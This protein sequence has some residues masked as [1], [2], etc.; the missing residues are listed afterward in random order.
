MYRPS[1]FHYPYDKQ[2]DQ[3]GFQVDFAIGIRVGY[4]CHPFIRLDLGWGIALATFGCWYRPCHF[5]CFQVGLTRGDW[6]WI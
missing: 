1:L 3:A 6:K 4:T 2:P 5:R